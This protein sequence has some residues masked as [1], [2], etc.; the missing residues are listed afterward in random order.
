[1][2]TIFVLTFTSLKTFNLIQRKGPLITTAEVPGYY[3]S[4]FKFNMHDNNFRIAFG[5][6]DFFTKEAKDDPEYVRWHL[7]VTTKLNQQKHVY[8]DLTTKKCTEEDYELFY[9]VSPKYAKALEELKEYDVLYCYD[10]EEFKEIEIFGENN[11]D[12]TQQLEFNFF[13][14]I[15]DLE[16]GTCVNRTLEEIKT[17]L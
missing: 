7:R 16:N 12:D 8:K 17:Y 5:I 2:L 14:C 3:D 9:P 11:N 10:I 6:R 13:P 1:M 15:E 4:S